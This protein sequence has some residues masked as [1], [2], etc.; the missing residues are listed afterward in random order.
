MNKEKAKNQKSK[1]RVVRTRAKI[2]GTS[3]RPRLTVKRT[4]LHI[5][6]QIID[7]TSG[8]TLAA[9]SDMDLEKKD[10]SGKKKSE[11]AA[12]VGTLVADRAKA[13]GIESVVFD[14]RDR[15]YH[16]RIKV[17]ADNARQAGLKF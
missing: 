13:K 3:E 9:A 17:L 8:R 11:V 4:L 12:M 1:R 16:G 10:L 5:Y 14:R 15:K 2:C 6:A 7:D